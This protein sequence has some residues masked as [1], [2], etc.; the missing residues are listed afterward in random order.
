MEHFQWYKT[1]VNY[2]PKDCVT[3]NL[4]GN[5]QQWGYEPRRPNPGGLAFTVYDYPYPRRYNA[6]LMH[7][8]RGWTRYNTTGRFL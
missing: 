6:P 4:P 3:P 7:P 1:H 8:G 5:C 2:P